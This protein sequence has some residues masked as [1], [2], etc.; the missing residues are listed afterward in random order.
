ME[1]D[2]RSGQGGPPAELEPHYLAPPRARR[3]MARR[4]RSPV[5]DLGEMAMPAADEEQSIFLAAQELKTSAER[6]DYLKG[7]CGNDAGLLANVQ[8][9]LAAHEQGASSLDN[10]PLA[11]PASID[12]QPIAE[13]PGTVI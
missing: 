5:P 12:E 8:G 6:V 2:A 4:E 1:R 9:L 10:P 7:A 11:G 13:R 3:R